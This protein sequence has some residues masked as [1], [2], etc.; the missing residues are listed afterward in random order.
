MD[1]ATGE[2]RVLTE[3]LDRQCGPFPAVR[4]PLWDGDSLLFGV[5]EHGN[6]HIR[7]VPVAGGDVEPVVVR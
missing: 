4:E 2:R 3:E 6:V 5:E 7:R 1:V